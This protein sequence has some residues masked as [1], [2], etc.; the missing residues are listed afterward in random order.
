MDDISKDLERIGMPRRPRSREPNLGVRHG[1]LKA[2]AMRLLAF[3]LLAIVGGFGIL[4]ISYYK[5]TVM[6]LIVLMYF[7]LGAFLAF[8][9]FSLTYTGWV[10]T[11]FL[12]AAGV[13]M[14][15]LALISRGFSNPVLARGAVAILIVSLCS[16]ALLW[17]SKD[18]FGIRNYHEVFMPYT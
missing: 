3:L 18:V 15:V 7:A 10:Y 9:L 5:S 11:L 8:K 12:A 13:L 2:L 14:P 16:A 1:N 4:V 6:L 17:W